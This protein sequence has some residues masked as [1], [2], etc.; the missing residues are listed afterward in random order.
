MTLES[1]LTFL[2]VLVLVKGFIGVLDG[3]RYLDYIRKHLAARPEPWMPRVSVIV[4]CKG[5][6][7]ELEQNLEAIFRQVYPFFEVLVVT[8]TAGDPA[9]APVK[10]LAERLPGHKIRFITAGVSQERGEKVHNLIQAVA[11][12]DPAS[13][14]F[15]FTDSDSRPHLCWL[16]ELVAPLKDKKVGVSTGYRWYYP[17]RANLASVIR[18]VWN[19]S[20]ATLLGNHSHNFAWGGSMAIRKS[21]FER[22]R[23]IDYWRHSISDDYSITQAMKD[24]KLRIHFEPRCLIAS[25]GRCGWRELLEWSTRQMIITKVYSRKLWR[26]VLVSQWTFTLVWWWALAGFCVALLPASRGS[27][28]SVVWTGGPKKYGL[29]AGL[30]FLFGAVRGWYRT[31]TIRRIR[32][33]HQEAIQKFW[34]GH[35]LLFPLASTLTAY[36][37]ARSAFASSVEWRGVRYEFCSPQKLRVIRNE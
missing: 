2:A 8:A 29:L 17:E 21:I 28:A 33:E 10:R 37:L 12:A 15:V 6:D 19:G 31:Q 5:L 30:L 32:P 3:V 36:C 11:C 7:F 27:P 18:S 13:E 20:I 24:A 34:W 22:S 14:V 16:Q 1:T 25:Y 35:A 4:P 26:L 9:V 23:V